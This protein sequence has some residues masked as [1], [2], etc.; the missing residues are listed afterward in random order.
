MGWRRQPECTEINIEFLTDLNQIFLG[1]GCLGPGVGFEVKA[2][3][4]AEHRAKGVQS[5]D[6]LREGS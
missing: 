1:C 2:G 6:R 3:D 5:L 4:G